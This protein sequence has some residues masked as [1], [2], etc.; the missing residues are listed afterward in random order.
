MRRFPIRHPLTER[1][2]GYAALT[3][4]AEEIVRRE[5]S[6]PEQ[7]DAVV[8][9]YSTVGPFWEAIPSVAWYRR[10]GIAIY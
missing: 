9:N 4:E 5:V 7:I 10:H 1:T 3:R 2:I 8:L 6:T